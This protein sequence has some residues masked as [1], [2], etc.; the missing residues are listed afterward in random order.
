MKHVL[1]R[2]MVLVFSSASL[3]T[4]AQSNFRE[5]SETNPVSASE[6]GQVKE[7]AIKSMGPAANN[8]PLY[9][10]GYKNQRPHGN[11][12]SWYLSRQPRENGRFHKGIPD[13]EWKGWYS[14]GQPRFIRTYSADK[15]ARIK[16]ETRRHPRHIFTPL[17]MEAKTNPGKLSKATAAVQSFADLYGKKPENLSPIQEDSDLVAS[18]QFNEMAGDDAYRAPFN[19]CLH[20][21]LYVNYYPNGAT[22]DSGYYRN[23]LREGH[24]EEWLSNGTVRASGAY[25]HGRRT[26][27]WSYYDSSGRL[28]SLAIYNGKGELQEQKFY[29]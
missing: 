8:D 26:Q 28:R 1:N 12:Q 10:A 4:Y 9:T 15:L 18:N 2:W 22:K 5:S 25:L 13:G 6:P 11:Y 27:T 7:P 29:E 19:E 24:W 16:D 20:H 17:A 3:N 21:G 14:N 23:G